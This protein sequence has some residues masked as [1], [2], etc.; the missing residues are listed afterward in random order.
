MIPRYTHTHVHARFASDGSN[1]AASLGAGA[2]CAAGNA[3][4][5]TRAARAACAVAHGA[6]VL[7]LS[8]QIYK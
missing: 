5:A 3:A 1:A 7:L 2:A 8:K 4:C 6:A